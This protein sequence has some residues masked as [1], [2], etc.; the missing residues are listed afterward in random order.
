MH[1]AAQGGVQELDQRGGP[2]AYQT[3]MPFSMGMDG[4]SA[5]H[6]R[7]LWTINPTEAI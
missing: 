1:E 3:S 2:A 7:Q 4:M 6:G 5:V